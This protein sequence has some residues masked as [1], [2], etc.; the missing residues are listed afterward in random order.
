MICGF[1][2]ISG[3]EEVLHHFLH[4]HRTAEERERQENYGTAGERS[5]DNHKGEGI[6][7][8]DIFNTIDDLEKEHQ[9]TSAQVKAALR[10]GFE[11]LALSF[12]SMVEGISH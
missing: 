7:E 11:V 5:E 2:F 4:P 6:L 9:K 8:K 3:L 12:H 10:T 1:F